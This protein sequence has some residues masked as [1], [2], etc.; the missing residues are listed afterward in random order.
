MLCFLQNE[1]REYENIELKSRLDQY[2]AQ[3]NSL[4][5]EV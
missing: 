2:E 5:N 1:N 4:Q 3:I